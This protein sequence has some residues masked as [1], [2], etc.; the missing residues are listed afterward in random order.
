[1]GPRLALV[2]VALKEGGAAFENGRT[3]GKGDLIWPPAGAFA[4]EQDIGA[5]LRKG[6][7]KGVK[8]RLKGV[9]N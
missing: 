3:K 7:W 1:M 2:G 5:K 8:V 6:H 9:R 4:V